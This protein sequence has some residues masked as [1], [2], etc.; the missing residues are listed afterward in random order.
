M[1]S[2][3]VVFVAVALHIL[4]LPCRYPLLLLTRRTIVNQDNLGCRKSCEVRA[5]ELLQK[6]GRA[7]IDRC[8][9]A[10]TV[11]NT[12]EQLTLLEPQS[13]CGDKRVKF[14]ALCPQNG[15]AV[16][17]GL[18]PRRFWDDVEVCLQVQPFLFEGSIPQV[19][20][21][22]LHEWCK[23]FYLPSMIDTTGATSTIT[24]FTP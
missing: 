23:I 7:V 6:G 15:T 19:Q 2:V 18:S 17:K 14:Q 4:L 16:L 24:R 11:H 20:R 9:T 3:S 1:P 22:V 21:I 13:R 12:F 8:C 10:S 5:R